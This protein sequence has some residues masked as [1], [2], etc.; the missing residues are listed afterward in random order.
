MAPGVVIEVGDQGRKGYGRFVRIRHDDGAQSVYAHFYKAFV[1]VGQRVERPSLAEGSIL[2]LT[3]N[4]GRSTGPHLHVGFR[5]PAW[6]D[7]LGNGFLGYVNFVKQ[8]K[9]S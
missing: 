3:D 4:T 9:S 2:G 7:H 5:P 6:Q 1:K 8:L